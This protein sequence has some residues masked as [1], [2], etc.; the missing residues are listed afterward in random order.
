MTADPL[1]EAAVRETVA[2]LFR[3]MTSRDGAF[4]AALDADSEGQEGRYY[5]WSRREVERLLDPEEL[6]VAETLY[7]LDKPANF[8]G[9]WNLV[10]RDAWRAVVERLDL[11]PQHAAALLASARAKLFTA[12]SQRNWPQSRPMF[13]A[14]ATSQKKVGCSTNRSTGSPGRGDDSAKKPGSTPRPDVRHS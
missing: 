6:L 5:V 12:R 14:S 8:E 4:H 3:D 2:W 13:A 10:R 1:F 11:A 7:G 9:R